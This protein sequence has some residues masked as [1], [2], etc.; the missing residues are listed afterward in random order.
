MIDF[1]K[2]I[3]E[4]T[5]FSAE[6]QKTILNDLAEFWN[7]QD[8]VMGDKG[9]MVD[10]PI[11]KKDFINQKIGQQIVSWIHEARKE[12]AEKALIFEKVEL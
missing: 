6:K 11:S 10:N 7:Y 2:F 3:G 8:Q 9:E 4:Q 5:K 1:L 12:K